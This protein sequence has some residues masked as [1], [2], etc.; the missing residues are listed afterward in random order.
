MWTV[1]THVLIVHKFTDDTTVV[2]LVT[3]SSVAANR[4]N[5]STFKWRDNDYESKESP[6]ETFILMEKKDTIR[7]GIMQFYR[8]AMENIF[9]Q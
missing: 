2:G 3:N 5:S 7:N 4:R 6:S 1:P 9:M 8:A